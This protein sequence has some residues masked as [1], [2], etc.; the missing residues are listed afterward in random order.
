LA[1]VEEPERIGSE[2]RGGGGLG[3]GALAVTT[4]GNSHELPPALNKA[5]EKFNR[6]GDENLESERKKNTIKGPL[7]HYTD[8]RGLKG[9]IDSQTI[10]FT[11]YRHLNDPSELSYGIEKARD[12][13]RQN[14]I[15]ADEY[16]RA[17]LEC[18][19][20]MLSPKK[21]SSLEF[22][23]ASFSRDKD[24]LGQWRAYADN[25]RGYVLGLQARAIEELAREPHV[26]VSPVLY[27]P[28]AIMARHSLAVDEAFRIFRDTVGAINTLISN[29]DI[30]DQ[31]IQKFCQSILAGALIWN[32][33]T[34]KHNAYEREEEVRFITLGHRDKLKPKIITRLRGSEIVPYIAQPLA[35]REPQM[36]FEIVTGPAAGADA[37]RTVRT[38]L[39]SFEIDPEL[40]I[41]PSDIPYRVL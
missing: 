28:H 37:V 24:E 36:I 33:L 18:L 29:E 30:L 5:I 21:F 17:F 41:E 3:Q 38:M 11:D 40:H 27:E 14:A 25:G 22:F 6:W 12:V 32:C 35:V 19:A 8:G 39:D 31:F 16:G 1:Q 2:A 7:Y 10:W 26:F 4:T 15:G 23:I 20:D 13:M 9:I 34:S